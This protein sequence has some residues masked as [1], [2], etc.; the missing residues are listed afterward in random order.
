VADEPQAGAAGTPDL[1]FAHYR[2]LRRADGSIW[3]LGR[4]AM[5]VTYKAYDE[6]LR[7]NVALKVIAPGQ[8]DD[9]RARG[10]FLREARAAARIRHPNVASVVY[11]HDAPENFFYAMEFVDGV[12]LADWLKTRGAIPPLLATAFATQIARGLEA[13]HAH[14][15]VHRDLKPAN[16][17]IVPTGRVKPGESAEANP[18]GWQIKI[19]DFGLARAFAGEG[20]GTEVSAPTIGFRGTALYA[21]PEQCEERGEIDG[22][23]D[24]YSLGCIL[25]EML[26]GAPPFRGRN[27]REILNQH[28]AQPVPLE[29]IAHLP[30]SL[31]AVL[32]RL[33]VKDPAN[34]FAD[35]EAVVKVLERCR[36][37]IASGEEAM[38]DGGG[39][40]TP[41]TG[42]TANPAPNLFVG[43]ATA[44]PRAR[45]RVAWLVLAAAAL[46]LAGGAWWFFR[47][48]NRA[49]PPDPTPAPIAAVTPTVALPAVLPRKSIAVLP[50]TNLSAEKENEYFADGVQEDVLTNLS[51]IADL[52]I[53]S[54]TSVMGYRGK[55]QNLREIARE[56]GVGCIVEGSVRRYGNQIRVSARLIDANTDERL[57]AENFDSGVS[58]VFA[59][60]SKIAQ[61]IAQAL[62]VQLTPSE[63]AVLQTGRNESLAAYELYR[64][65]LEEFRKYRK[66]SNELA[67]AAFLA[68]IDKDPKYAV[69]YAAL[70][71]AYS[72]KVDKLDAP[73]YWM[74][75]ALQAAEYAITIDPQ[76]AEAYAAL[77]AVYAERGWLRP[78]KTAF[79]RAL[80]LNPNFSAPLGRLAK[81]VRAT[82]DLAGAWELSRRAVAIDPNDPYN[83]FRLGDLYF[84]LGELDAG[85]RWMRLGVAHLND[86]GKAD[87]I[88]I[89][90][91]HSRRDY[92]RVIA[93]Y[94]ARRASNLQQ[95]VLN[96]GDMPGRGPVGYYR[97]MAAWQLGDIPAVKEQIDGAV[98]MANPSGLQHGRIQIG[99]AM[100]RRREGRD[101]E[102]REAARQMVEFFKQRID[103]G[104]EAPDD[105][106]NLAVGEWLLG[107]PGLSDTHLDQAMRAGLLVGKTDDTDMVPGTFRE[108][109]KFAA[110]L[111]EMGQRIE[112]Q[113]Q[114]IR[115][116]EKKLP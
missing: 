98:R 22:R 57:W 73:L 45:G 78:A 10:L 114:R 30:A 59:I 77:G 14:Q 70:S 104:S 19:I 28:V 75:S 32:A 24:Q 31:Q 111:T 61:Q 80:E 7:I 36:E 46:L 56:L 96:F 105:F 21:S 89:Q 5:G 86:P 49:A 33:L 39:V 43:A 74:E 85:E 8:V 91:A 29:R 99:I 71:A 92:E 83:Y 3:E 100:L 27:H 34:R 84:N 116:L 60:Q 37:R 18:E 113:R 76:C 26:T 103:D 101:A 2:V 35:A 88:E 55:N 42:P 58:D 97:A 112:I 110:A 13:I 50:F 44:S 63:A 94:Q 12:S 47:S 115:E 109:P 93:L 53:I 38:T 15:I 41:A 51:R 54:R 25:W 102:M 69:A 20:L 17:M 1:K 52:K 106:L 16:L 66:E 72:F 48:A 64:R 67:I 90:L 23:S 79:S 6:R 62:E 107:E 4:G 81:I 11:L 68:A 108:N 65:G 87:E 95:L 40:T 9:P 82:G